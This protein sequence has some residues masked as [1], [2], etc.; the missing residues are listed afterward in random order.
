V[1]RNAGVMI[2]PLI[3]LVCFAVGAWLVVPRA[4]ILYR[5]GSLTGW[6]WTCLVGGGILA[7][8]P[9]FIITMDVLSGLKKR[10]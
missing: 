6:Q 2:E 4:L 3:F 7:L 5:G 9:V 10:K 8:Y 1:R